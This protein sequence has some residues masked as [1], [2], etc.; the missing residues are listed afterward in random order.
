M[1]SPP[2]GE[3]AVDRDSPW[4]ERQVDMK[5]SQFSDR[6][7]II[8]HILHSIVAAS[9][10]VDDPPEIATFGDGPLDQ[11]LLVAE[12]AARYVLTDEYASGSD[13]DRESAARQACQAKHRDR[14]GAP[15]NI[16]VEQAVGL[17][18]RLL[19]TCA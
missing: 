6:N 18:R 5:S 13:A 10:D 3:F 17:G 9:L 1:V 12:L 11:T 2:I 8:V 19:Q 4:P 14:V 7:D 15:D 16:T